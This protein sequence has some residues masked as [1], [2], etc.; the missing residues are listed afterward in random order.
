[1]STNAVVPNAAAPVNDA[2]LAA[3]GDGQEQVT[4]EFM[5][6]TNG[7]TYIFKVLGA[8]HE[9]ESSVGRRKNA[10]G[11]NQKAWEVCNVYN[12]ADKKQYQLSVNQVLGNSLK[13]S[14]PNHTYIGF[15]FRVT[16]TE[17]K[18]GRG[19]NKYQRYNIV[20][21]EL[22]G[23]PSPDAT[24]YVAPVKSES[25]APVD[26]VA[27][28]APAHVDE[29]VDDTPEDKTPEA[30]KTPAPAAPKAPAKK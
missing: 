17:V 10:D 19:G 6:L 11:T 30:P 4:K 5:M 21:G 8:I 13:E 14:Y 23:V 28:K 22:K 25:D 18:A 12:F 24:P 7:Q 16:P 27:D 26:K 1:M 20:R 9:L 15:T 29:H 3:F 2:L